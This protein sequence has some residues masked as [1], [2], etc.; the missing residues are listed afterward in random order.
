MKFNKLDKFTLFFQ[1]ST[2][3]LQPVRNRLH[4]FS[5]VY[6]YLAKKIN[7]SW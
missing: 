7:V 2:I 6:A 5:T 1:G 4:F 3:A